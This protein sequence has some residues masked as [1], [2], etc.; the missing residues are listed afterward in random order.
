MQQTLQ[1]NLRLGCKVRDTNT[2]TYYE[3]GSFMDKKSFITLGHLARKF[4][5][6][7]QFFKVNFKFEADYENFCQLV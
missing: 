2:L 5:Q 4:V 6:P 7:R 1:T 3:N